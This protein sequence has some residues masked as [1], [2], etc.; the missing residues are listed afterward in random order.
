MPLAVTWMYLETVIMSEVCQTEKD[1]YV[2]SHI[3]SNKN[4]TNELIYKRESKMMKTNVWLPRRD[5]VEG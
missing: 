4:D 3:E 2:V 1:K 5:R